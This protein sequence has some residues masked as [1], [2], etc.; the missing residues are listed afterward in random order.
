MSQGNV[1]RPVPKRRVFIAGG[2]GLVGRE[3]VAVRLERGAE[4]VVGSRRPR[5]PVPGLS[6]VVWD[7]ATDPAPAG[8]VQRCDVVYN[9]IGETIGASRWSRAKRP[10]L[11]RSRVDS[12][13][14]IVAAFGGRTTTFVNASAVSAYPGDGVEHDEAEPVPWPEAASFITTMTHAW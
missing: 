1:G 2:T 3:L 11:L 8:E 12:T 13:A 14:K 4:V 9:L 7:P 5:P 10:K 6:F